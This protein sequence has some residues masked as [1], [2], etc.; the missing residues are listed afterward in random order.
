MNEKGEG[1]EPGASVSKTN[2]NTLEEVTRL[3]KVM[4]NDLSRV[5]QNKVVHSFAGPTPP[6]RN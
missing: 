3:L 1:R 4:E 2:L 6:S 5:K